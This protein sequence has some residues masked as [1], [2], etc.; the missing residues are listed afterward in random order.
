[1]IYNN[2]I[3]T[4]ITILGGYAFDSMIKNK[5][6]KFIKRFKELNINDPKVNKYIEGINIIRPALIF[7][8]IY[9]GI[10]PIFSTYMAEKI[11]KYLIK[12]QKQN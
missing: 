5:T 1:M 7:A 4:A 10:L 12:N 2:I 9:Y 8:G 3:S 6:N 11:D